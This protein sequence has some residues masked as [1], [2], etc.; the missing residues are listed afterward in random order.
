MVLARI[1]SRLS[2]AYF[3]AER[4][5]TKD[6]GTIANLQILCV[7]DEPAAA[8][9]AYGLDK[10]Y[11]LCLT[12]SLF[13]PFTPMALIIVWNGLY[14]A[15][16]EERNTVEERVQAHFVRRKLWR[17]RVK[18]AFMRATGWHGESGAA[19]S[20]GHITVDFF[21]GDLKPGNPISPLVAVPIVASPSR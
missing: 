15:N 18:F 3:N 5:T 10:K 14:N 8:T 20:G 2:P 17:R 1:L 9:I 6:T 21:S 16:I 4:Q 7:I 12:R 19:E 11:S 13:D